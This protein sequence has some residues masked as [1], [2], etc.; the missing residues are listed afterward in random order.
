MF[1]SSKLQSFHFGYDMYFLVPE[2]STLA[3]K[4]LEWWK[5][6]TSKSNPIQSN[7][8]SHGCLMIGLSS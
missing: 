4:I 1:F 6:G 7:K 2:V 8:I 5:Y 3:Q